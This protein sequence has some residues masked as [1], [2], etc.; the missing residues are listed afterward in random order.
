[1][2]PG[3]IALTLILFSAQYV[4]KYLVKPIIPALENEYAAVNHFSII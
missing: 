2:P 1:M 4:D 3:V